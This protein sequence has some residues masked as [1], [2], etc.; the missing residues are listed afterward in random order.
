MPF[1]K[2]SLCH[3]HISILTQHQFFHFPTWGMIRLF[4]FHKNCSSYEG[5]QTTEQPSEIME[6]W[7][8]LSPHDIQP[9]NQRC[10]SSEVLPNTQTSFVGPLNPT[11][12]IIFHLI[13]PSQ[14]P[15]LRRVD[16]DAGVLEK[17]RD[18]MGLN[19]DARRSPPRAKLFFPSSHKCSTSIY[20]IKEV[21]F[22]DTKIM[23]V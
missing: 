9:F 13:F 14:F 10:N 4:F 17:N 19:K 11:P 7:H 22:L 5:T 18:G 21:L 1:I 23:S 20:K 2:G 3:L 15:E 16:R 6:Q 8:A 12:A